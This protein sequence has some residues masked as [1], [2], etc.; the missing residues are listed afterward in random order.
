MVIVDAHALRKSLHF[1]NIV[2]F[3]RKIDK[4]FRLVILNVYP[5]SFKAFKLFVFCVLQDP[6]DSFAFKCT[7]SQSIHGFLL[8]GLL[9]PRFAKACGRFVLQL[10]CKQINHQIVVMLDLPLHQV[11]SHPFLLPEKLLQSLPQK[12]TSTHSC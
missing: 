9:S 7:F 6:E 5:V 4:V 2:A 12:I 3:R 8:S 11:R 10:R 1:R